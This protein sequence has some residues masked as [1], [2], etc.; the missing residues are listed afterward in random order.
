MAI[1][2]GVQP[3]KEAFA[4]AEP[5]LS[6]LKGQGE[7]VE[8]ITVE[9]PWEALA[10]KRI[11]HFVEKVTPFLSDQKSQPLY[12]SRRASLREVIVAKSKVVQLENFASSWRIGVFFPL[13][14]ALLKRYF[15]HVDPILIDDSKIEPL[16]LLDSGDFDG[17]M[18]SQA[19]VHRLALS[20][21]VT[22]RCNPH[23]FPSA[24]GQGLTI[25]F[26]GEISPWGTLVRAALHRETEAQ[27]WLCEQSF[28]KLMPPSESKFLFGVASVI[29]DSMS[30]RGGWI[31]I[32]GKEMLQTE[33]ALS[34][35]NPNLCAQMLVDKLQKQ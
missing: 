26:G 14:L 8:I 29:G 33:V 17:L 2:I 21:F 20:S 18:L 16:A 23:T 25:G 24:I 35:I 28:V 19:T 3:G 9:E 1:K 34:E 7:E 12:V 6:L 4:L 15:G 30:M 10:Q 31:S 32:D 13:H 22:Q 27:A 11:H 5:I